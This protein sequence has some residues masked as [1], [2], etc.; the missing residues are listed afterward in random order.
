M[1]HPFSS[2]EWRKC[3]EAPEDIDSFSQAVCINDKVY[4]SRGSSQENFSPKSFTKLYIYT[5]ATDSWDI[6]DA[7]V[8]GYALTTYHSQLVLVGGINRDDESPSAKLWTLSEDGQWKETLPPMETACVGASAVSH[9]DHLLVIDGDRK[10]VNVYNCRYWAKAEHLPETILVSNSIVLND[11]LYVIEAS[12]YSKVYSAS[13][14]SLI[15]S[16]QP[17]ETSQ[18]PSVWKKLPDVPDS[19]FYPTVF[20]RRL[21]VIG[22]SA[23]H[24]YF[25]S[26]QSWIR[27]GYNPYAHYWLYG[28]CAIGLPSNELM[29]ILDGMV[30]NATITSKCSLFFV[31]IHVYYYV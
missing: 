27:V 8:Y 4:F 5:P 26:S 6:I 12:Y 14:D 17:S 3:G 11:N 24:A 10:E 15:A 7:P 2:L 22:S 18:P 23:I 25:P 29:V 13:L 20:G 1:L 16:C 9:G 19:E 31:V 30:S 28:S 21:T